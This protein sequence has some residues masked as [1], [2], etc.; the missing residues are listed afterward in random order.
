[1]ALQSAFF[2]PNLLLLTVPDVANRMRDLR[3]L[4]EI[5]RQSHV[6]VALVAMHPYAGLGQQERVPL[7]VRP[8]QGS[9]SAD[10]AFNTGSLNLILLMGLRVMRTWNA[11]VTIITAIQ[12]DAQRDDA[13]RFLADLCELVRFPRAAKRT[14]ITGTF[15]DCL[16][17]A[18]HATSRSWGCCSTPSTTT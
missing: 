6:G 14:V 11:R 2:R 3:A 7:W 10:D 13:Q 12:D 16:E 17:T 4:I 9:W 8:P 1:M 18:P 5:G 15:P